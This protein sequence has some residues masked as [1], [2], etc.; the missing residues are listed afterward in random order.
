MTGVSGHGV[1]CRCTIHQ[2]SREV[3]DMQYRQCEPGV[4]TTLTLRRIINS[5][6]KTME[7]SAQT[8]AESLMG[9]P[10]WHCSHKFVVAHPWNMITML[11]TLLVD[12][13]L[14]E[15]PSIL[16]DDAYGSTFPILMM[17]LILLAAEVL[18][19]VVIGVVVVLMLVVVVIVVLMVLVMTILVHHH[20]LMMTATGRQR[21]LTLHPQQCASRNCLSLVN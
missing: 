3:K 2:V 1:A 19:V 17:C 5:L 12:V 11:P 6:D 16:D 20:D 7:L 15:D 21:N 10:S 4:E 9:Y 14:G 8:A 13:N 18:K